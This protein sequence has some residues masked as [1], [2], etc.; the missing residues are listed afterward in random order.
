MYVSPSVLQPSEEEEIV[1]LM[2]MKLCSLFGLK[3][4]KQ[5]SD[6]Q[7]VR[8]FVSSASNNGLSTTS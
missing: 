8:P 2:L 7:T 1:D 4:K 3:C 5:E 6:S